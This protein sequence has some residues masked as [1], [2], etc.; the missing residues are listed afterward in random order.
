METTAQETTEKVDT[1]KKEKIGREVAQKI[2][3]D[4]YQDLGIS[5]DF[6]DQ[7]DDDKN[8]VNKLLNAIMMGRLEYDNGVFKQTLLNPIMAG[9]KEIKVLEIFEPSGSDLREMSS[10]KKKNDDVGKALAV[11][12]SV[13]ALGLP[14]INKMKSRDMMV[15][16]GVMSLF[17]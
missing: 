1:T 2:L 13:T 3:E 6:V 10:V 14:V 11:L 15:A 12:A 17:L 5:M 7:E 4:I 9:Q 8:T 16:V